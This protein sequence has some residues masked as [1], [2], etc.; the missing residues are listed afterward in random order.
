[1][2]TSL[3]VTR[4]KLT[5]IDNDL[6]RMFDILLPYSFQLHLK[7]STQQLHGAV[8]ENGWLQLGRM[9]AF[10]SSQEFSLLGNIS[11]WTAAASDTVSK[12]HREMTVKRSRGERGGG[13]G[14]APGTPASPLA[15]SGPASSPLSSDPVGSNGTERNVVVTGKKLLLTVVDNMAMPVLDMQ[16]MGIDGSMVQDATGVTTLT[17]AVEC[18]MARWARSVCQWEPIVEPAKLELTLE[19]EPVHQGGSISNPNPNANPNPNRKAA[20][21]R[22]WPS[23]PGNPSRWSSRSRSS[24]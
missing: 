15:G 24:A 21:Y 4:C 19:S 7:R 2:E 3:S 12:N 8:V 18:D 10:L 20:R 13:G 1:M 6:A 11:T 23:R 5:G 22:T 14:S 17:V 9:E 16:V